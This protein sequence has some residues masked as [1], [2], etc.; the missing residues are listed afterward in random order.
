M[1]FKI[2][3]D[4]ILDMDYIE[5]E[6]DVFYK[7]YLS[8]IAD[9]QEKLPSS[10][11]SEF[12]EQERK[13]NNGLEITLNENISL[14]VPLKENEN[15]LSCDIKFKRLSNDVQII[16]DVSDDD[17]YFTYFVASFDALSA[18]TLKL[19]F[20]RTSFVFCSIAVLLR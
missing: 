11:I 15:R 7:S 12:I 16:F 6:R 8:S 14:E 4:K 20:S 17:F 10:K 2:V 18:S 3:L 5:D 9:Y 1:A 13:K 19:I